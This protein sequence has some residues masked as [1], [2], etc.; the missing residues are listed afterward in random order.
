MIDFII[1]AGIGFVCGCFL[2]LVVL[3]FC[4]VAKAAGKED[5]HDPDRH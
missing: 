1:A 2:T 4:M 3:S 5:T